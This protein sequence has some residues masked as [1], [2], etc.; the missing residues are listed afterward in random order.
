MPGCPCPPASVATPCAGVSA[1]AASPPSGLPT[2]SSSTRRSRSRCSPTTGPRTTT[3]GSGSSRRAATCA[4]SSRRTSCTVYDAGELDDGRPY[5]V[6]SYADQG[7]LADRLEVDGLTVAPGAARWSARS[8]PGSTA[9]HQRGVLHRDVKPANVLFRT[10]DAGTRATARAGDGRRPRARQGA[11]HVLAADDDRR[12]PV[13][14]RARAGAGRAPRRPGR[15]V[16]PGRPGLPAAHRPPAVRPRLA[17]RGRRARRRRRRCRRRSGRSRPPSTTSYA[18]GSPPTATTATPTSPAFVDALAAALGAGPAPGRRCRRVAAGRPRADPARR[19]AVAGAAD[20][21]PAA[22]RSPPQRRRR[23]PRAAVLAS[24][25]SSPAACGGLRGRGSGRTATATLTD[26]DGTLSVTVPA[27][28]G[29]RRS[30]RRAGCR[31]TPTR[32]YPALSVGDRARLADRRTAQGVF[33]GLLPGSRAAR[34]AA[35]APRVRDRRDAGR[36]QH[37]RRPGR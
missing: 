31:P 25:C 34:P 11:R 9:L 32:R 12:H 14:R 24:C 18:A 6:M 22:T 29:P 33:V 4:R 3:S 8:G 20:G 35:A 10:V 28:L 2:T 27:R 15:P 19:P 5:L 26:D 16:L 30:R 23:W 1:P 36:R 13:V 17:V 21:R 7:T 37:R